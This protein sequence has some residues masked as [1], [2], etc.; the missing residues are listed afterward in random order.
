MGAALLSSPASATEQSVPWN[1]QVVPT[2]HVYPCVV[3]AT[4]KQP[5]RCFFNTTRNKIEKKVSMRDVHSL[6]YID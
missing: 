3:H 4:H 1:S 2:A 5:T 6:D